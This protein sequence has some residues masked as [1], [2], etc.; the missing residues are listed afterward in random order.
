MFA[1]HERHHGL[2]HRHFDRLTD[3]AL[4]A[5]IKRRRDMTDGGGANGAVDHGHRH[6]ARHAIADARDQRGNTDRA[7]DQI[8]IGRL[9]RIG[10]ALAVTKHAHIDDARVDRRD[11]GIGQLQTRHGLRPY[12]V[13]QHVSLC[14][15]T[16]QGRASGGLFQ[17]KYQRTLVTIAV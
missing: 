3:A 15:Q 5:P 10:A 8:V 12:V 11:V 4:L 13:D 2:E 17:I 14:G 7:L 9:G 16:Q 6:I 1:E